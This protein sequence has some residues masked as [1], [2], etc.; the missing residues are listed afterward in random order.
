MSLTKTSHRRHL[1]SIKKRDDT[2][3][4][5]RL[6]IRPTSAFRR[7]EPNAHI[8]AIG[9]VYRQIVGNLPGRPGV[10]SLPGNVIRADRGSTT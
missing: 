2:N 4:A 9:F 5:Q 8:S 6:G 3:N 7:L 10:P 1:Y